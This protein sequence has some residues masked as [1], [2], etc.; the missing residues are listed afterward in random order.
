[1]MRSRKRRITSEGEM[2]E[3][4][5][6]EAAGSIGSARSRITFMEE[7]NY[8]MEEIAGSE[9]VKYVMIPNIERELQVKEAFKKKR[10]GTL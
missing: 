7:V 8:S 3:P 10:K 6:S 2:L 9:D 5:S 4:G 1:M